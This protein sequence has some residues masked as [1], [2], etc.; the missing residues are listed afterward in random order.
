MYLLVNI[1]ENELTE[2]EVN[3]AIEVAKSNFSNV[4]ILHESDMCVCH[5]TEYDDS[6]ESVYEVMECICPDEDTAKAYCAFNACVYDSA[7]FY[8][9]EMVA[10]KRKIYDAQQERL[11]H[12]SRY[13]SRRR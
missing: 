9:A 3:E 11:K 8:T 6:P 13:N 5:T 2:D 10:E 12:M 7:P 1:P 4:Q